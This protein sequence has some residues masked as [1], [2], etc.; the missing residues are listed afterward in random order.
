MILTKRERNVIES[1]GL[2]TRARDLCLFIMEVMHPEDR[3]K[4]GGYSNADIGDAANTSVRTV[5]R[6]IKELL[7]KGVIVDLHLGGHDGFYVVKT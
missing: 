5:Q 3:D 7:D 4:M 6:A 2:S 1:A